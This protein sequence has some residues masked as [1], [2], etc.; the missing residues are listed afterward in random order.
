M[1]RQAAKDPAGLQDDV[2]RAMK[3][4]ARGS[5][6]VFISVLLCYAILFVRRL[7]IVRS[8]STDDY[9]LFSLAMSIV[10]LFL[11]ISLLG[12]NKGAQ[13]FVALYRG[14][15]DLEG[16]KGTVYGTAILF[17]IAAL[18][19][20]AALMA[21]SGVMSSLLDK[22]GLGWILFMLAF[23]IPISGA[24]GLIIA[25][26]QG[27]EMVTAKIIGSIGPDLL[28][29]IAVI[30]AI[31]L[32][33]T[34]HS[35]VLALLLGSALMLV[36]LVLYMYHTGFP[37]FSGIKPRLEL[38]KLLLFSVPLGIS[39]IASQVLVHTDTIMLG[40]FGTAKQVG[41][42]NA[43]VPLFHLV[44]I[45]LTAM[46]FIYAPVAARMVGQGK[47]DE[48]RVLYPNVTKW[49]FIFT[50]PMCFI[51][52]FYPSQVLRL[53]FGAR[54][55]GAA[56]VLQILVIGAFAHAVVGPNGMTLIAY[57]KSTLVM[58]DTVLVATLNV[59]LNL[60]FIPRYGISGA[61]VATAVSLVVRNII[62]SGQIYCLYRINPFNRDYI[63]TFLV[64]VL[65]FAIFYYPLKAALG[66]ALW[67]LPF[68]Y[69]LLL[70]VFV[71]AVLITRSID[72]TDLALYEAIKNRF[73]ATFPGKWRKS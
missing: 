55:V 19:T 7:V 14:K 63:K 49:L 56:Y 68:C 60:I 41:M 62:F 13:R 12:L 69:F 47:D 17:A 52:L 43:A 61:A 26:Y 5:A 73:L 21:T 53:L 30:L 28:T 6:L 36:V 29:T 72:E 15:G 35:I 1:I 3:V 58:L 33:G 42:Y 66:L 2:S 31:L 57:G 71:G 51:F 10:F 34:L 40:Y 46:A 9:G 20:T 27:F 23:L 50:L 11:T 48:L 45:F 18:V 8:L 54:Y 67:F 65:G 38:R 25:C 32:F 4:V 39:G 16:A 64:S 44:P 24:T 37:G 70:S 22:P 59:I